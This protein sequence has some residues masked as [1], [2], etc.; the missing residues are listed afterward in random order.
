MEKLLL[1]ETQYLTAFNSSIKS[2]SSMLL[3][4]RARYKQKQYQNDILIKKNQQVGLKLLN[5]SIT[6]NTLADE[7]VTTFLKFATKNYKNAGN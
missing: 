3:N 1:K 4:S 2:E 5:F 7:G 6:R